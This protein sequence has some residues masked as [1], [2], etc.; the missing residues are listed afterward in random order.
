MRNILYALLIAGGCVW[1]AA[2]DDDEKVSETP[3]LQAIYS[4]TDFDALGGSGS[5]SIAGE[6]VALSAESDQDW[7]TITQ[8]SNSQV[9]FDVAINFGLTSRTAIIRVGRGKVTTEVPVYQTGNLIPVPSAKSVEFDAFGGSVEVPVTHIAPFNAS[10]EESAKWIT[11]E[12][13]G[14]VLRLTTSRN[15]TSEA[16]I[17]AVTVKSGDLE[18]NITVKQTGAEII[19]ETTSLKFLNDDTSPREIKVS[20]V[21]PF[22]AASDGEWLTVETK[23]AS[24]VL[25]PTDNTGQ[26]ERT[27][28][29]TLSSGML[30]AIITVTQGDP[31]YIDYLGDWTLT[32]IDDEGEPFSYN[33]NITQATA[34]STYKV[35]GWGGSAIATSSQYAL[36]AQFDSATG[37]IRIVSQTLGAYSQYNMAFLGLVVVG[38]NQ[39]FVTG[40]GYD[41]YIGQLK[42]D[43]SVAW[44]N[45]TVTVSGGVSYEIIGACYVAMSG[46]TVA[47]TF[48]GDTPF[49]KTPVMTRAVATRSFGG[50]VPRVGDAKIT[51]IGMKALSAE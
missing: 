18:T 15:E 2:C 11:A 21:L 45:G 6:K 36:T 5:L 3:S 46:G 17:A 30:R 33:L 22:T 7:C 50:V 39:G 32:A 31:A 28:S 13:T 47:G 24:I 27:A 38:E 37:G 14:D 25:T 19:P 29:V 43:G 8:T 51:P 1:L 20:S 40:D 26:A 44:G 48:T 23:G 49:M 12:V 41:C 10:I 42:K 4:A 9:D 16:L 35:I 34:G